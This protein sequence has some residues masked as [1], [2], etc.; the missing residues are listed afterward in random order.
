MY[1]EQRRDRVLEAEHFMS[2][3]DICVDIDIDS[4]REL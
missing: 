3:K 4:V 1:K 2:F